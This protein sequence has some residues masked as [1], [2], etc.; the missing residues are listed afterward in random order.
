[1][2]V[3]QS[4]YLYARTGVNTCIYVCWTSRS[5][6]FGLTLVAETTEGGFYAAE[7][8]SNPKGSDKGPTVPEDLGKEAAAYLLEEI[9]KVCNF[10]VSGK[11]AIFTYPNLQAPIEYVSTVKML[12]LNLNCTCKWGGFSYLDL[13]K[14]ESC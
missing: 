3:K 1:M 8:V 7:A 10:F 9:Y 12:R 6:G 4:T 11:N 5:P 13:K 14:L 2:L